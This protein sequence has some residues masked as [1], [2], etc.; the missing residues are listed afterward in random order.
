MKSFFSWVASFGA[1]LLSVMFI[2]GCQDDE[3][4]PLAD[5]PLT[6]ELTPQ[7]DGADFD[8]SAEYSLGTTAARTR[9]EYGQLY[10]SDIRLVTASGDTVEV[11]ESYIL[12]Y[13]QLHDKGKQTY[14][15]STVPVG[16]YTHVVFKMGIPAAENTQTGSNPIDPSSA[17]APL[18]LQQA[19]LPPDPDRT[20]NMWWNWASGYLFQ[21]IEGYVDTS[22]TNDGGELT[23][24]QA[25][26]PGSTIQRFIYHIGFDSNCKEV[27]KPLD[28]SVGAGGATLRIGVD[29]GAFLEDQDLKMA[30]VTHSGAARGQAYWNADIEAQQRAMATDAAT[31]FANAVT[32]N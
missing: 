31:S 9:F 24:A 26:E 21:R 20:A 6:V 10:V 25:A 23:A 17:D 14:T 28:L 12:H 27:T 29:F 11:P 15:L 1:L 19:I 7:V 2:S 18:P 8:T 5:Q 30:R 13:A 22:A 3:E 32:V 4:T 16:R